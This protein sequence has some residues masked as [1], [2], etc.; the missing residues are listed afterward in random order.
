MVKTVKCSVKVCTKFLLLN[1][2][3]I[4]KQLYLADLHNIPILFNKN[5]DLFNLS[6]KFYQKYAQE[7][8]RTTTSET[9][10]NYILKLKKTDF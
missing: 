6:V 7:L 10:K 8:S 1:F 4:V 2:L 9:A 3:A 5:V